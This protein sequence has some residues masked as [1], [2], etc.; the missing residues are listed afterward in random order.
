MLY[1]P[2]WKETITPTEIPA[3]EPWRQILNEAAEVIKKRGWTTSE[4]ES[5]T[6]EVCAIGAFRI[7]QHGDGLKK[8]G[9]NRK[10]GPRDLEIAK[11]KFHS[12][13]MRNNRFIGNRS[14]LSAIMNWNDD[15][16]SGKKEIIK[17]FKDAA[18][19]V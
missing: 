8:R 9:K 14:T 11:R 10:Y 3:I 1:D 17:M 16:C 5:A 7:V 12:V 13:I 18:N 6:G 4:F 15:V 19:A 2:K